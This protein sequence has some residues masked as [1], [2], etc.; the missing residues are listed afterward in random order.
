MPVSSVRFVESRCGWPG[1]LGLGAVCAMLAGACGARTTEPPGGLGAAGARGGTGGGSVASGGSA[2]LAGSRGR[3]G[4][5]GGGG[6]GGRSGSSGAAGTGGAG[7]GGRGGLGGIVV[8]GM[9]ASGGLGGVLVAGMV[10]SG[11]LGGGGIEPPRVPVPCP[12][13]RPVCTTSSRLPGVYYCARIAGGAP[14]GVCDLRCMDRCVRIGL[15]E[16]CVIDCRPP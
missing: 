11:G 16:W 14:G 12:T 5:G 8:G 13:D 10:A 15:H 6:S 7:T 4:F 2:G 3:G 9:V 1:V